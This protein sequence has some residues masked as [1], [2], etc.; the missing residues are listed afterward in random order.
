V[1][2]VARTACSG[3]LKKVFAVVVRMFQVCLFFRYFIF[4]TAFEGFILLIHIFYT[5]R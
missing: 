3:R 2:F 4:P 5:G 1:G